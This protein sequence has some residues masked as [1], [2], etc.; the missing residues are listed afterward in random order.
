MQDLQTGSLWSQISGE[1]IQGP[2]KGEWLAL[3]H[4]SFT[5]FAQFKELYPEG[6]LLEK[7][8]KEEHGSSYGDYYADPEKLGIFGRADQFERLKGKEKVYGLRLDDREVAV[9]MSKLKEERFIVL[10]DSSTA[11]Q[12]VIGF[13][14][15]GETAYAFSVTGDFVSRAD[16]LR[17]Q[18]GLVVYGKNE[19]AWE[20][21]T[22]R[23]IHY[24]PDAQLT[25]EPLPLISA[26][27]FA[28]VSFF[29]DTEL[30]K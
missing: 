3:F 6:K 1:A 13:D 19:V 12:I 7:P 17:H 20:V 15:V 26:Y 8:P 16:K 11:T 22:G 18:G 29:A 25:V 24:P 21:G 23:V 5:T 28:W 14:P 4:S 27:W 2:L 10:Q 9:V 30:I